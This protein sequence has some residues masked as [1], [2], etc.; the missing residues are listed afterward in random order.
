LTWSEIEA[1]AQASD[2]PLSEEDID[3]FLERKKERI[4][5]QMLIS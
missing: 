3:K 2:I 1:S 4:Q 5:K